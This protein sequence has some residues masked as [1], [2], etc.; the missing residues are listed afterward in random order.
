MQ[1]ASVSGK[2][3]IHACLMLNVNDCSDIYIFVITSLIVID[4]SKRS[5]LID[6]ERST[7]ENDCAYDPYFVSP[8]SSS[9]GT[10]LL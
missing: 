5:V 4:N 6:I 3:D 8:K 7:T 1:N 2:Y 9:Y 10:N